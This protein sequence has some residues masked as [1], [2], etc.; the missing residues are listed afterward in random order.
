VA[1]SIS[2]KQPFENCGRSRPS[3]EPPILWR[4]EASRPSVSSN[5]YRLPIEIVIVAGPG[6]EHL[7]AHLALKAS[8]RSNRRFL[9]SD[10]VRC[11]AL[12]AKKSNPRFAGPFHG[13]K[14]VAGR[15]QLPLSIGC[16]IAQ[17]SVHLCTQR[18]VRRE[19]IALAR[20]LEGTALSPDTTASIRRPDLR[21][22]LRIELF[23]LVG[24]GLP[25]L[26][27]IVGNV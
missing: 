25:E 5:V 21:P 17:H 1:A 11:F 14:I 8:G 15:S 10:L 3:F 6:V 24:R 19:T 23:R 2:T 18:H 13:K 16:D 9:L 20:A 27:R 26:H 12:G 7:P 22:L 4:S